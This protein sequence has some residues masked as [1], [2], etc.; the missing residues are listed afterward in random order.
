[1]RIIQLMTGLA[2]VF[3]LAS[4]AETVLNRGKLSEQAIEFK[5]NSGD[6]TDAFE[7][8]IMVPENRN[9]PD[10]RKIRVNYVRFPST[11]DNPGHPI[12]YLSGGPGGSGIATAK[13]RR[14]LLFMALRE[15]GDV[16]A[17]DQ[18]GTGQSEQAET[19]VSDESISLTERVSDAEIA[20]RYREAAKHCLAQWQQQG[21]DVY[22]YTTV[23]NALDID[24]LRKHLDAEKVNLWGIS[25]GSHLALAAVKLF[26]DKIDKVI[27]ASAEGLDQ[28]IKLPAQTNQ[29]FAAVNEV[30]A[31]QDVGKQ[32]SDL[33]GLMR[34]VHASLEDAPLTL[35]IPGKAGKVTQMLFQRYHMQKLSSMAIADPGHYLAMLVQIYAALD[36]GDT[37]LLVQV[38][39]RGF[40]NDEAIAFRLMPLAMDVASGITAKRLN[41]VEQQMDNALLGPYLNFPMPMLNNIDPQLDLGDTFRAKPLSDVPVLLLTGSLDGRTYPEEQRQAVSSLSKVTQIIVENAGH[42]LFTS[43]PEV[44]NRMKTFLAGQKTSEATIVLPL[45]E[46]S[47]SK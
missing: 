22:G 7:G 6:S 33:P 15:F 29:Y 20:K 42:N 5:A 47:L 12:V 26:D 14:F 2:L 41:K 10:S 3:S 40:F 39:Q 45:P 16:I 9:N 46:L 4:H 34:R 1:M 27:I 13:W 23:Q 17:L 44:L 30:L 21:V 43:H 31:K 36:R 25:Y 38:L 32:V 24:D 28:T 35:E 8:F 18:R 11:S 37:K 19:C